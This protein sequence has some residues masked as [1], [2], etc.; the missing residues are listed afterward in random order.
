MFGRPGGAA[1]SAKRKESPKGPRQAP[2]IF[3]R[4]TLPQLHRE[5]DR[6]AFRANHA[7]GPT[8]RGTKSPK[9]VMGR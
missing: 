3:S 5:I 9:T 2:A 7:S 1:A 4:R 6:D 8:A